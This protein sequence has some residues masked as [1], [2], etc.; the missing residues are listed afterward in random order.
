M[1]LHNR[2]SPS[3][4]LKMLLIFYRGWKSLAGLFGC[5]LIGMALEAATGSRTLA[6][7]IA[8]IALG[9]FGYYVNEVL[10]EDNRLFWLP[11]Q[12]LGVIIAIGAV[13]GA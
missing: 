3:K 10:E 5:G 7:V 8:G 4:G 9:G 12:Y 1:M 6:Y 2:R 13:A 11:I